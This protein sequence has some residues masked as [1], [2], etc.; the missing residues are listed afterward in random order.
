M[1]EA[2]LARLVCVTKRDRRRRKDQGRDKHFL[3]SRKKRE[4]EDE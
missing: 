2:G 1:K 3:R 4:N